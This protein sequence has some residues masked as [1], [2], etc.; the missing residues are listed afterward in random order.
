MAEPAPTLY[1]TRAAQMFPILEPAEIARV[2]RFGTVRNFSD[3]DAIVLA[4]I[5]QRPLDLLA[6]VPGD[7]IR[8][9]GAAE[10]VLLGEEP[11][12]DL[13]E[14]GA[15]SLGDEPLEQARPEVI[16][17][18][19]LGA[20]RRRRRPGGP[21]SASA[22]KP[23]DRHARASTWG[24]RPRLFASILPCSKSMSVHTSGQLDRS[25]VFQPTH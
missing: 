6:Q 7:A 9:L 13:L 12:V 16:H 19:K 3:G 10:G 21:R 24:G 8:R 11:L 18:E 23:A 14:L 17:A 15:Q 20:R 1:D 22:S 4:P 2:R 25:D 5:G